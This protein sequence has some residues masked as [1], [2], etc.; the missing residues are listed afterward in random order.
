M[1]KKQKGKQ[2]AKAPR[3][4]RMA[5][6]V[7]QNT[8]PWVKRIMIGTPTTG[9]MRAEWMSARFSQV[10]PTNWSHGDI[11]QFMSGRM[12]IE[13]QIADAENLIAKL[14]VEQGFEWLFFIEHDNI[15]PPNTFRKIN[16]YM[17]EKKWPIIAG[18]YFTKSVPP[19]PMIYRDFGTGYFDKWKFGDKVQ[20][21]G[22]PF[23]CTLIH[24]DIIREMWKDAPEYA[25][26]GVLTRRVFDN[27]TDTWTDPVTGAR[28]SRGGTTDLNFCRKV[29]EG[30]Y[31]AK[32]GWAKHQ[33]MRYPFLVDTT[34]FVRHI[35]NNGIQWPLDIPN[36]FAPT[37]K[38]LAELMKEFSGPYK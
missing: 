2:L 4:S 6:V 22:L 25:V 30:G 12:P 9:L 11:W 18:L 3:G 29:I 28:L 32:A 15:L 1:A 13:Y 17:M 23:G 35:D 14:V 20:C 7:D 21:N 34:I 10:L 33:K 16:E 31:L 27:P 26:N 37:D 8:L 36:K 5:T 24:G 38:R 19:E